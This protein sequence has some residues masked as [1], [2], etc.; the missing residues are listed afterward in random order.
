VPAVVLGAFG[1]EFLLDTKKMI[2]QLGGHGCLRPKT[3]WTLGTSR[4]F[5]DA[6]YAYKALFTRLKFTGTA[7]SWCVRTLSAHAKG[8]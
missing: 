6:I 7:F 4:E 5:S 3:G 1:P 8:G 2:L